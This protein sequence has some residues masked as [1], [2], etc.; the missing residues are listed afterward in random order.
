LPRVI[1]MT[2]RLK[3]I[4]IFGELFIV[5]I[6]CNRALLLCLTQWLGFKNGEDGWTHFFH[7]KL[8]GSTV[9]ITL[10]KMA[11][12]TEQLYSLAVSIRCGSQVILSTIGSYKINLT[13]NNLFGLFKKNVQGLELNLKKVQVACDDKGPW[14][15]IVIDPGEGLST[16]QTFQCRHIVAFWMQRTEVCT[17]L[18]S[19]SV[20]WTYF[21]DLWVS[22]I[23]TSIY[24]IY[25]FIEYL[26]FESKKKF[27]KNKK[28]LTYRPFLLKRPCGQANN[29][30]FLA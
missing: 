1:F 9:F 11:A 25:H 2:K 24:R 19:N 12:A 22:Y 29:F 17:F 7:K 3:C 21:Y 16:L 8:V 27:K 28:N 6:A 18:P 10:L 13:I 23:H 30:F 14:R 4:A 20:S 5:R 15:D 26:D